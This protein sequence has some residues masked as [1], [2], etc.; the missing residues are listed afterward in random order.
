MKKS[1]KVLCLMLIVFMM[2]GC[3]KANVIMSINKDKSMDFTMIQAFN[4]AMLG[5]SQQ[6]KLSDA[7][8]SETNIEEF[9]QAGFTV[10]NYSDGSWT[11]YKMN[12]HFSN[13]DDISDEEK[14]SINLEN[15]VSEQNDKLFTVKKGFFKNSY[16]ASFKSN[17]DQA[18]NNTNDYLNNTADNSLDNFNSDTYNDSYNNNIYGYAND[19][20]I[21]TS[22]DLKFIINLPYE[23]INSNA[24][25]LTNGGKT[26]TWDLV[27]FKDDNIEFKFEIYNMTNIYLTI[28]IATLIIIVIVL[29]VKHHKKTKSNKFTSNV[30]KDE[31]TLNNETVVTPV[32]PITETVNP[33]NTQPDTISNLNNN[34]SVT[35]SVQEAAPVPSTPV[36]E[37]LTEPVQEVKPAENIAQTETIV[38]QAEPVSSP[39][40]STPTPFQGNQNNVEN[41]NPNLKQVVTKIKTPDN[42]TN[43]V[44]TDKVNSLPKDENK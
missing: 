30:Q 25:S 41:I 2:T 10:E 42:T 3:M 37:I 22:M 16:T 21:M 6:N 11:G 7:D 26:L 8:L 13:I 29:I 20:A 33:T 27:N 12:K 15:L 31:T 5:E 23:A 34:I 9:K 39:Q 1:F 38:T 35:T 44:A 40:A 24:T 14:F 19:Y 18:I 36:P 17:T 32:T 43:Q 4:N 28:G